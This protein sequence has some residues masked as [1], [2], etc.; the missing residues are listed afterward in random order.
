MKRVKKK[1][2]LSQEERIRRQAAR[3]MNDKIMLLF[4]AAVVDEFEINGEQVVALYKRYTRYSSHVED[5]LADMK[6][7]QD[8]IEKYCDVELK[9]WS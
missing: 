9:G 1:K 6:D 7:A 4:M 5:K 2:G 8:T 3:D